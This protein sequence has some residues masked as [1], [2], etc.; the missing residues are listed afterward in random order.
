MHRRTAAGGANLLSSLV[1]LALVL[2]LVNYL[3]SRHRIRRDWTAAE[4]FTLSE[5]TRRVLAH[6]DRD[7]R[8]LSFYRA[9][10]PAA[11]RMTDLVKMYDDLSRRVS[12]ELVD[13]D[14]QP[15]RASRYPDIRYGMTIVDA[16]DRT[17]RVDEA[18]EVRLTNAIIQATR[19]ERKTIALLTG[20]GEH[21]PTVEG[22]QGYA[23]FRA[24]LESEGFAVEV[25]NLGAQTAVPAHIS[26]LVLAG[27]ERELLPNEAAAI[28]TWLAGGGALF[29]LAD[30]PPSAAH[31]ALVAPYGI[32][33]ENNLVVDASGV[34]RLFGADEFLPIGLEVRPHPMTEGF[35]LTTVFPEARTVRAAPAPPPG[36]EAVEIV[37]SAEA[38]WAEN[39][40]EQQPATRDA[41]DRTGPLCLVAA[42]TRTLAVATADSA[43]RTRTTRI[44]VAGDSDFCADGFAN[45]GGNLDLAMNAV[46]WLAEEEDLIAIRPRETEDRR[47]S[48][49]QGQA[50][51]IRGGLL[52]ALPIS[53]LGLGL[54]VWWRRR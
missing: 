47:V 15:G 46:S 40:P 32:A 10:D 16:G 29:L 3:A 52:L 25:L 44:V 28:A 20:H 8:I 53:I 34:G 18:A 9:G 54:V 4:T 5:Q 30:P 43:T 14:R 21:D 13:P 1:L 39:H 38:S 17:E 11:E 23:T 26:V 6:L 24:R 19:G 27:A 22:D 33:I 7:V 45:F 49:T 2:V 41:A 37:F 35:K 31:A 42:A 48:L 36:V 51:A 12:R 50:A